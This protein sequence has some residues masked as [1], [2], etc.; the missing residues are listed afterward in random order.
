MAS[1]EGRARRTFDARTS[2]LPEA[3]CL[4]R[5]AT[6]RLGQWVRICMDRHAAAASYESLSRLSD[7][8]LHHRGLSRASLAHDLILTREPTTAPRP[9]VQFARASAAPLQ[10]REG[11]AVR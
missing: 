5:S 2:R 6:I 10:R 7:A 4:L 9:A 1:H 11:N 8:E 3:L